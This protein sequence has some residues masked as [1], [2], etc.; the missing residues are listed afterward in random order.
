MKTYPECDKLL[1]VKDQSQA[2]GGFL[3]WLNG[4]GIVLA[5]PH[6]HGAEC[7]DD[8]GYYSCQYQD[9]QLVPIYGPVDG[10]LAQHFGIDMNKVEKERREMLAAV[11]G[12]P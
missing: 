12:A 1:A 11:R 10:L 9:D 8:N 5:R 3:E 7:T 2:I 6:V 4:E